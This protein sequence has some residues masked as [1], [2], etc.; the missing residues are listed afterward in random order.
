MP[1]GQSDTAVKAQHKIGGKACDCT[2]CGAWFAGISGFDNHLIRKGDDILCMS[3]ERMRKVGMA[4]NTNGVWLL[5]KATGK[6]TGR[7]RKAA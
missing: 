3:P 2:D 7:K 4:Q 6:G 5:G 1:F